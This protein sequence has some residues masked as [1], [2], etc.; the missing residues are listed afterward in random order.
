MLG[1]F[2]FMAV[3]AMCVAYCYCHSIGWAIDRNDP[4]K[5]AFEIAMDVKDQAFINR[6]S[7][8]KKGR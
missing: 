3:S 6:M 8:R 5:R 4:L 2:D 1:F 7:A